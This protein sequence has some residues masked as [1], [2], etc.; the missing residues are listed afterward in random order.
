MNLNILDKMPHYRLVMEYFENKMVEFKNAYNPAKLMDKIKASA[1][2]AGAKVVYYVLILYYALTKGN[3]PLKDRIL[4]IAALGYF[5]SPF[6]FIPDFLMAG[7]LDDMSILAF[8]ASRV[9]SSIDDEVKRLAKDKLKEWFGDDEIEALKTDDLNIESVGR[10]LENTRF[11]ESDSEIEASLES[12]LRDAKAEEAMAEEFKD[13]K[14]SMQFYMPFQQVA[15]YLKLNNNLNLEFSRI[16]ERELRVV[17]VKE[18]FIKDIRLGVNLKIVEFGPESLTLEYD[19]GM[20]NMMI[21]PAL[22]YIIKKMP[23]I[24][25]GVYKTDGNKIKV[26]LEKI[27]K[28]R[29]IIE[30]VMIKHILVEDDGLKFYLAFQIPKPQK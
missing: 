21:S 28:T 27:D 22:S 10:L 23:E 4:V 3:I 1:K 25:D 6:D 8:V 26:E 29:P 11:A 30:K 19:G 24:K 13:S 15:L 5:I 12:L 16:S 14:R 18:N 9:S 17:W 20:A 7:L 2:K